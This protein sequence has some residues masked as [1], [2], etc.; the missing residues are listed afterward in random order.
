MIRHLPSGAGI[1]AVCFNWGEWL[2]FYFL[3]AAFCY[4]GMNAGRY[5]LGTDSKTLRS[6]VSYLLPESIWKKKSFA[7]D[8]QFYFLSVAG[9]STLVI[10]VV[11]GALLLNKLHWIFRAIGVDQT[12]PALFLQH[13]INHLGYYKNCAVFLIAFVAS[14]LGRYVA[15]RIAHTNRFLWQFHKAHHYAK[16]LN[17]FANVRIHPLDNVFFNAVIALFVAVAISPFGPV[18]DNLAGAPGIF[19]D[20]SSYFYIV[21]YVVPYFV[22]RLNHSHFPVYYGRVVDRIFVS[23]A[24]HIVHHSRVIVDKNYGGIFSIWDVMF[25]T[26]HAASNAEETSKVLQDLGVDGMSDGH[27]R[28]ALAWFFYPIVD[29]A[30][31]LVQRVASFKRFFVGRVGSVERTISPP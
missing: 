25:G 12:S 16:Q 22:S 27:Y 21:I 1:L 5:L 11:T 15:H 4:F 13:A 9:F 24:N 17:Y 18:T 30:R 31:L 7:V 23:P 28:N 26:Y 20:H 6:Y 14:D 29:F 3:V 2:L 10:N 19:L 8:L